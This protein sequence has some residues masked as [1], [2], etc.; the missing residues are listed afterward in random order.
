MSELNN[1]IGWYIAVY[2][3]A[4]VIFLGC[5]LGTL[6]YICFKLKSII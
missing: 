3:A 4:I 5:I 2:G 1:Y 6:I